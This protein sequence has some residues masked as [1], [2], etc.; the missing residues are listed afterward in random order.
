M[1]ISIVINMLNT[2]YLRTHDDLFK[3][4]KYLD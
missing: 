4:T 1:N 3:L 2:N